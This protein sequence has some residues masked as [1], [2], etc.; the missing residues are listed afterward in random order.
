MP[1]LEG[2]T[3]GAAAP[4]QRPVGRAT[5]AMRPLRKYCSGC[6]DLQ[7]GVLTLAAELKQ[8]Q[9]EGQPE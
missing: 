8:E 1:A 3:V 4:P 9:L 5:V 7:V 2:P 6:H